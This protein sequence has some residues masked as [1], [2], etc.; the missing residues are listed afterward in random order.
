LAWQ[1]AHNLLSREDYPGILRAINLFSPADK[2]SE[3]YP[4][5]MGQLFEECMERL[6]NRQTQVLACDVLLTLLQN[7]CKP[8]QVP[9]ALNET[10]AGSMVT[11]HSHRRL[12]YTVL[13]MSVHRTG[14]P[15]EPDLLVEL[16]QSGS[17]DDLWYCWTA[18]DVNSI[19][20]RLQNTPLGSLLK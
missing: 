8:E 4:A 1:I 17:N 7:S 15:L 19:S 18:H 3:P 14:Q 20:I 10:V 9:E 13:G 12:R 2:G 5:F 6:A 16:F 11:Q